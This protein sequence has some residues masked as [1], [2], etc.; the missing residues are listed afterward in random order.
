MKAFLVSSDRDKELFQAG[1]ANALVTKKDAWCSRKQLDL[2]S[3]S[4]VVC[5][6]MSFLF[7]QCFDLSND[8][9]CPSA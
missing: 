5:R 1:G 7:E 6:Y 9:F 3:H 8:F 2:C 4:I